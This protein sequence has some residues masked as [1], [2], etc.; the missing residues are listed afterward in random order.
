MP[1]K[2]K[3]AAQNYGYGGGQGG[4]GQSGGGQSG[5]YGQSSNSYG[6]SGNPYGQQPSNNQY[7][8]AQAGNPYAQQS[9]NPYAQQQGNPYGQ[10]QQQQQQGG[11]SYSQPQR[12]PYGQGPGLANTQPR[13]GDENPGAANGAPGPGGENIPMGPVGGR[14]DSRAILDDC[15]DID[16]G[17]DSV[18]RNIDQIK[19]LQQRSLDDPDGGRDTKSARD[20]RSLNDDTQALTAALKDRIQKIKGRPGANETAN[21]GQIGRVQRKLQEAI[22]TKQKI[23]SDFRK[24]LTEQNARQYR[25]VRPDA[26]EAE[27]QQASE[28]PA[29]MQVFSQAVS[30]CPPLFL[31]ILTLASSCK[32]TAAASRSRHFVP[33]RAATRPSR[34]SSATSSSWPIC[35]RSSTSRS[36]SKRPR[37][38]RSRTAPIGCRTT[39]PRPTPS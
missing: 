20:L 3:A 23:D 25:I 13:Y 37:S 36:C 29:G 4:Y 15:Q 5:G 10:Q 16:R 14:G 17:I 21:R 33:F 39:S 27:V 28:D 38:P 30:V 1:G 31:H 12:N 26:S 11:S 7:G 2:A 18:L 24:R 35:T 6:Q 19:Y 8:Q 9:T 34:K 22:Q 32:A